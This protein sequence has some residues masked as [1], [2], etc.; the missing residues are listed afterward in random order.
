MIWSMIKNGIIFIILARNF[1]SMTAGRK[2][3]PKVVLTFYHWL[4]AKIAAFFYGYPSHQ[5]KVIG[6]TGTNGKST[7]CNLIAAIL[8]EAGYLVGMTTTVNFKIG[9]QE[10]LNNKKMTMLGRFQLQ[11]MLRQMV[12]AGCQFA[13]IESSSQGAIQ[14]RHLGIDFDAMVFTNLTPEHIE[15]HGSFDNYKTAKLKLFKHLTKS[16][17]KKKFV[18]VNLDDEHYFDFLQF[19]GVDKAGFSLQA[20]NN[21]EVFKVIYADQLAS[22]L[23]G[24]KFVVK[25]Q[26]FSSPLLGKF[27]INNCLA[28]ITTADAFGI[29]LEVAAKA[30]SKV[31]LIPGRMEFIRAGQR[32]NILVDYAPEPYSLRQLY[33]TLDDWQFDHLI[34]VLGSAGGGR[35]QARRPI[36]GQMAATKADTIIVTNE[37]PYDEDP[38]FIIDQIVAGAQPI[39]RLTGKKFWSILDRREA[40]K[41]A[42]VLATDN[43]LVLI[44]GKGSEQAICLANG[45]MQPWDDRIVVREELEKLVKVN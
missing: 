15:A 1:F 7:T 10:W 13:I 9:N 31:A 45:K 34:H 40:I 5:L 36:L 41:K 12:D 11:K 2:Y 42:L 17:K 18:I 4:L 22:N 14:Y 27:N 24:I 16:S 8:S 25:G 26:L 44:T 39:I 19:S 6:V 29:S 21:L 37:D 38:Q 3:L 20:K 33:T 35:D 43:D 32:F 30:L 23:Q 28:A